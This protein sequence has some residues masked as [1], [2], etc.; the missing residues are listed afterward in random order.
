MTS[1][2]MAIKYRF[3]QYE[4]SNILHSELL[5]AVTRVIRPLESYNNQLIYLVIAVE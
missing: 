3:W 5:D 2:K 4:I 1:E